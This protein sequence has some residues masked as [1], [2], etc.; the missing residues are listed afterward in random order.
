MSIAIRPL[1]N[2]GSPQVRNNMAMVG[3]VSEGLIV[4]GDSGTRHLNDFVKYTITGESVSEQDLTIDAAIDIRTGH[5]MVGSVARGIVFGGISGATLLSDFIRYVVTGSD[6][7]TTELS[8]SGSIAGRQLAGMVGDHAGGLI[9]GGYN[10]S[11]N[12]NDFVRYSVLSDQVTLTTLASTVPGEFSARRGMLMVGDAVSGLIGCGLSS[13]I[14]NDFCK[15]VVSGNNVAVTALTK[16]GSL[17]AR[18]L[19]GIMGTKT[20]GVI[21]GGENATTKLNDFIEYSADL[22]ANTIA[23]KPFLKAGSISARAAFGKVGSRDSGVIFGGQDTATRGDFFRIDHTGLWLGNN[24]V[25]DISEGNS[26]V[27]Q[28]EI[29]DGLICFKAVA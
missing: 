3:D 10:G 6:V 28:A 5:S 15:Y 7:A 23:F 18:A 20:N 17:P 9:Y 13:S 8:K 24:E 12:F 14:L 29:G 4:G 21:F 26:T 25:T 11:A 27:S 22:S 19:A 16:T 1:S 2:A